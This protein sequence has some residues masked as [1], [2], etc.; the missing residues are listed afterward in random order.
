MNVFSRR[1]VRA[2]FVSVP[3][4]ASVVTVVV[5]VRVAQAPLASVPIVQVTVRVP[6]AYVQPP[7]AD[8]NVRPPGPPAACRRRPGPR[9]GARDRHDSLV[10]E[11][12]P[13]DV[14][15]KDRRTRLARHRGRRAARAWR[16][17]GGSLSGS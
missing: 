14:T 7:S 15:S 16:T 17:G 4:G 13:G 1:C 9:G 12:P 2:V 11:V 8:T 3:A 5:I 10:G 6:A